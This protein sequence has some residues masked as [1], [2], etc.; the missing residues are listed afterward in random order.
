MTVYE[1][2]RAARERWYRR[3]LG[4]LDYFD[5]HLVLVGTLLLAYNIGKE[6]SPLA[7]FDPAPLFLYLF[8]VLVAVSLFALLLFGGFA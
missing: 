1:P 6:S 3:L 7:S 2:D 8:L 5:W 4:F